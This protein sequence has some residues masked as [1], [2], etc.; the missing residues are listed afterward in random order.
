MKF[1]DEQPESEG[2][3]YLQIIERTLRQDPLLLPYFEAGSFKMVN[4]PEND[5]M[6]FKPEISAPY[7]RLRF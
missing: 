4:E 5:Y 7:S 1:K 6:W 2:E 3:I